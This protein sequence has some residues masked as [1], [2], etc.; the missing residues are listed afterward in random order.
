[1]INHKH[2]TLKIIALILFHIAVFSQTNSLEK[3]ILVY[4]HTNGYV[5]NEAIK[6]GVVL[7]NEIGKNNGVKVVH[8]KTQKSFKSDQLLNYDAIIFLC[9]TLDV[10]DDLQQEK[11]IEFIHA[12]RGFVGVHAAADTEYDWPWYGQLLGA[13]FASHPK[14]TPKA[15]IHTTSNNSFFTEHL[16]EKWA[17]EDEWYNYNFRNL[18][19][20][21][22]LM[23]DEKTYDGGVNG[24]NHP[25][26]WYHEFEGGRSFYTGLGHHGKTY[27][28]ERFQKLLE[29][30]ILY[31][32]D[33]L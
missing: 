21:P 26:T 28:D 10:L 22:L 16:E 23:L 15:T 3:K 7:I 14:G 27:K 8:S 17:I 30:G 11:F 32:I 19:I 18:N 1:M 9:T 12:G 25:I 2:M 5:H 33:G 29:K 6:Q 13:Y 20:I 31:A 24:S 4:T